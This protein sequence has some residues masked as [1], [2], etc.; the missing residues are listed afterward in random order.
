[1]SIEM[2]ILQINVFFHKKIRLKSEYAHSRIAKSP[3]R[4]CDGL[5]LTFKDSIL[6]QF[7]FEIHQMATWRRH[8]RQRHYLSLFHS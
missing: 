2:G 6:L 3:S 7:K 8:R 4:P 5:M 1:M